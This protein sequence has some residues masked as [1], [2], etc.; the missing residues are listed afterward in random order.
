[1][2][3]GPYGEG[4]LVDVR[5]VGGGE[6]VDDGLAVEPGSHY[7][8][9]SGV[10]EVFLSEGDGGVDDGGVGD[11]DAGEE[12]GEVAEYGDHFGDV[13]GE[14]VSKWNTGRGKRLGCSVGIVNQ[15]NLILGCVLGSNEILLYFVCEHFSSGM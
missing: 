14:L 1:M 5:E 3:D 9:E 12:A 13:M 10:W 2:E 8:V 15:L 11:G 4:F 6:V 7:V